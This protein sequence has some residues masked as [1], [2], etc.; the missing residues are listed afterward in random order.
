MSLIRRNTRS[1]DS[2]GLNRHSWDPFE[3]MQQMLRWDPL[4]GVSS[5]S[6]G[7]AYA[8]PF[9]VRETKDAFVFKADLPG[10]R[11]ED[12]D[13]SVTNNRVTVSGQRQVETSDEGD[14]WYTRERSY[15]AFSR[16]F[17]LP[18]GADAD[19]AE[20]EL[21]HGVLSVVVPKKAEAKPRRLTLKGLFGKPE[22]KS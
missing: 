11:E 21:K 3:V 22:Q 4:L 6:P 8:P 18:E 1:E 12:L 20:A 15:G 5:A 17:S 10:L 7:L 2:A 14:T 9:E 16:T 19:H 13:I